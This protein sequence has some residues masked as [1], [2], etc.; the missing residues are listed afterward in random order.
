MG[1][2]KGFKS[3][4]AMKV[5]SINVDIDEGSITKNPIIINKI[6]IVAPEITYEKISVSNNFQVLLKNIQNS[7]KIK[8]KTQTQSSSDGG[9]QDKKIVINN[10][11]LKEGKVNLVMAALGGKEITAPL[12]DIHLKDIGKNKNGVT[13]A[14]AFEQIFSSLYNSI[15]ADSVTQVFNDGLKQLGIL[16]D[17]GASGLQTGGKTIEKAVDSTAKGVKSAAKGIKSLFKQD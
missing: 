15:S 2:P 13:P 17:F 11:V 5:A 1:N 14:Q 16:K 8:G 9:L 12:P 7:A 10:V 6:E 3:D 4:H